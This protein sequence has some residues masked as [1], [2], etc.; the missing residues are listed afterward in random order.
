MGLFKYNG[1]TFIPFKT[2]ADQFIK[3]N[4][5]YS[6]GAILPDGTILLNSVIGGAIVIDSTGKMLHQ[7][8]TETG[9]ID[10]TIYF[11]FVD[12]SGS[13]MLQQITGSIF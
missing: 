3:D 9:T 1:Q 12:K 4:L 13:C 6:P 7:Y 11:T 2:E 5:I 10:N 8:N